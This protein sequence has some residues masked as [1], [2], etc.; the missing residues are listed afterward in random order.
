MRVLTQ[1]AFVIALVASLQGC[2]LL[3]RCSGTS[4]SELDTREIVYERFG[5]PDSVSLINAVDPQ[6]SEVRQFEVEHHHVHA[7]FKATSPIWCG[8]VVILLY[9][10]FLIGEA[11]YE[12]A[13]EIIEG[14]DLAFVYDEQGN[15]IG[16]QG[17]ISFIGGTQQDRV[18]INVLNWDR[19]EADEE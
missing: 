10:P 2:S 13:S 8:S 12:A 17:P 14:H 15:T 6:T 5:P 7:K 16:R 3:I 11:L 19:P 4:L 18:E 1:W 9:E